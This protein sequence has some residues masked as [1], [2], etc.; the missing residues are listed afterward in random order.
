MSLQ[1]PSESR[2]TDVVFNSIL[3]LCITTTSVVLRLV[4][5]RIAKAG[6]WY[7]DYAIIVA[8]S[9]TL[10]LPI[11]LLIGRCTHGLGLQ[12]MGHSGN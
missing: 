6:F 8:S 2:T 12:I 9:L 1:R 7:D 10:V 5:R 3:M 4:S 11:L